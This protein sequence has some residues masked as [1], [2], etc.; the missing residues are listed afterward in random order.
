MSTTT[1]WVER[2]YRVRLDV[3]TYGSEPDDDE[4]VYL[5][6]MGGIDAEVVERVPHGEWTTEHASDGRAFL[7]TPSGYRVAETT[8]ARA[9]GIA[10]ALNTTE[11]R[12][13]FERARNET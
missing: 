6:R 1:R 13:A 2:T 10:A 4:F 3:G 11:G 9:R 8:S 5:L 7:V 12:D